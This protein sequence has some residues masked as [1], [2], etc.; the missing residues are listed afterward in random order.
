[1]L[2]GLE[3]ITEERTAELKKLCLNMSNCITEKELDE[4]YQKNNIKNVSE[5]LV[6]MEE[7]LDVGGYR[8]GPTLTA[9]NL[10]AILQEQFFMPGGAAAYATKGT[11]PKCSAQLR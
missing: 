11:C 6:L 1:M 3:K 4:F 2:E 7:V 8:L 5:K 10:Y 9:E